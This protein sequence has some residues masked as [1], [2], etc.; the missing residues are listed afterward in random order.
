MIDRR[1]FEK[2]WIEGVR[3]YTA[4]YD[5]HTGTKTETIEAL[6][7]TM[8]HHEAV[9]ATCLWRYISWRRQ[10]SFHQFLRNI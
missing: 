7:H 2:Q 6:G 10:S 5:G 3:T 4:T 1:S 8:E 9:A